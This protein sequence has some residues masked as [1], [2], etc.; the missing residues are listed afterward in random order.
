MPYITQG[1]AA[2]Y[3]CVPIIEDGQWDDLDSQMGLVESIVGQEGPLMADPCAEEQMISNNKKIND[4]GKSNWLELQDQAKL[5][6]NQMKEHMTSHMEDQQRSVQVETNTGK[7]D[8]PEMGPNKQVIK[9]VPSY[10]GPAYS[11]KT[12]YG[13]G[14]KNQVRSMDMLKRTDI[15]FAD[16]GATNH[17]TFSDKGCRNKRFATGSTYRVVGNSVLPRCELDI[18]CVHF[19]KDGEQV[20]EVIIT[21]VSHLPEGNFNLFSVTRLQKKGWTLTGNADYIKLQKGGKS[22]LFNI[23]IN[24]NKGALYAGKF[25]KKGGDEVVGGATSK[26]PTYNIK[27]A[28][29]LLE[30]NNEND[31]RQ[32]ASYLCWTITRGSLGLCKSCANAKT[33]QKNLPKTSTGEKATVKNGQWFHYSSTLKEHTGRKALARFGISLLM[34]SQES[35]LLG[36]T[37][38]K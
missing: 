19:D 12:E 35:L 36:Y 32:M 25:C 17:V 4:V 33:R 22:L 23:V 31:T 34:S 21:D 5:H 13:L 38:R 28:H 18:P 16:S 8:P 26:A 27:K 7:W 29:E 3:Y 11:P 6:D 10:H 1:V 14:A 30:H 24:T 2:A 9:M 15:W 20:G 37:T